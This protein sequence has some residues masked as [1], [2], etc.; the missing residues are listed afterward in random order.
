MTGMLAYSASLLHDLVRE[1]ADHDA[2][3]HALQVLRH[4]V[5]RLALAQVDLGRREVERESTQLLD[6]DIEGHPR[7]QR[8]LLEDQGQRLALQGIAVGRRDAL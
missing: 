3:H 4:V 7:A 5:D 6:A 1:G 8:R 2:L